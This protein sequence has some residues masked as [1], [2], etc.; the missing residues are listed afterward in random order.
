MDN[1]NLLWVFVDFHNSLITTVNDASGYWDLS[2]L[3]HALGDHKLQGLSLNCARTINDNH[4]LLINDKSKIMEAI[5][6]ETD[7]YALV[8]GQTVDIV[9]PEQLQY[10]FK[11]IAEM[12]LALLQFNAQHLKK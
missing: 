3:M 11:S 1:H 2:K 6:H 5:K 4:E 7:A 12:Q 8:S 10:L 9:E